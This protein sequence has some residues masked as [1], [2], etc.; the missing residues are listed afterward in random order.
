[1]TSPARSRTLR[2]F[3][4]LLFLGAAAL[5]TASL[6]A[7]GLGEGFWLGLLIPWRALCAAASG[8]LLGVA[9]LRRRPRTI[10]V[11]AG[12]LL[13]HLAL[14]LLPWR[15]LSPP[16]GPQAPPPLVVAVHNILIEND[17]RA[18]EAALELAAAGAEV[19][20]LLEIGPGVLEE[21]SAALPGYAEFSLPDE[22]GFGAGVWS[23]HPILAAERTHLAV[24][25]IPALSLR[26][27]YAGRPVRVL[28][29]HAPPP[30]SPEH[31]RARE[32]VIA[33]LAP[34]ADS[35]NEPAVL[36]GDFNMT[37]HHPVFRANLST[38]GLSSAHEFG[39]RPTWPAS[40]GPLG[41]GLDHVLWT[42]PFRPTHIEVGPALGSDHRS[43]LVELVAERAPER[44]SRSSDR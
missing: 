14:W 18:P 40:L 21:V 1:M 2:A 29:T 13:L 24:A 28:V 3:D 36:L 9:L 39:P 5:P 31:A 11:A 38:S 32:Q 12:A 23:R 15:S 22:S 35:S 8:A 19:I 6:L 41:I 42:A 33:A 25:W 30:V 44:V 37:R 26:I 20:A 27:D 43:I 16:P 34:W 4:R 10:A 7:Y 17:G